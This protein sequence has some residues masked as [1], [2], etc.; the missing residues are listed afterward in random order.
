MS[1]RH[2]IDII[3]KASV[4]PAWFA[5]GTPIDLTT[6]DIDICEFLEGDEFDYD[7]RL[8]M[9]PTSIAAEAYSLLDDDPEE[10]QRRLADISR[11]VEDE[12]TGDLVEALEKAPPV[13]LITPK[14]ASILDGNHRTHAAI[15]AGLE[16]FP[17]AVAFGQNQADHEFD[18]SGDRS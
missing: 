4:E 12:H 18:R 17:A 1:L 13:I 10:S 11:W 8:C 14:G 9:I 3:E 2:F 15:E 5:N 16:C 6:T 7:W